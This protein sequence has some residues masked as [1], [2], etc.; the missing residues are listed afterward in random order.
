MPSLEAGDAFDD[1][2]NLVAVALRI[3]EPF[4]DDDDDAFADHDAVGFAIKRLHF[5]ARREGLRAA[6]AEVEVRMLFEIETT[7][8]DHLAV[9]AAQF[10]NGK[11]DRGQ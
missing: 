1:C 5:A 4:E 10:V 11:I 9:A 3:G 6:E 8:D 2:V 7:G